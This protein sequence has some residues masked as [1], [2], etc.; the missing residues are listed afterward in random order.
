MARLEGSAGEGLLVNSAP[1]YLA[2]KTA[3]GVVAMDK[4]VF[5]S[6]LFFNGFE[7]R[8]GF[9]GNTSNDRSSR[10]FVALVRCLWR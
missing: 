8:L 10:E 4:T 9:T 2:C 3:A 1:S 5:F 6:F 7:V